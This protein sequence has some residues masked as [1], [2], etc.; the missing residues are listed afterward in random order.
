MGHYMADIVYAFREQ[1]DE[2]DK[3][4][5]DRDALV[6]ALEAARPFVKFFDNPHVTDARQALEQI[7]AALAAAK[8][9]E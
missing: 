6:K 9:G 7:D 4:R 5:V 1:L 8:E 3:L 2:L